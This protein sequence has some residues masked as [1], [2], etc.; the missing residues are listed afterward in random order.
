MGD[1]EQNITYYSQLFYYT[2]LYGNKDQITNLISVVQ[3]FSN[4]F[5]DSE[6]YN[7]EEDIII[8]QKI[9]DEPIK[10]YLENSKRIQ[11][12]NKKRF[13]KINP[14]IARI[15]AIYFK[16][17]VGGVPLNKKYYLDIKKPTPNNYLTLGDIVDIRAFLIERISSI[18]TKIVLANNVKFNFNFESFSK[19]GDATKFLGG[20]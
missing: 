1:N 11:S 10:F 9:G 14:T 16:D 7:Q 5:K 4:L 12:K 19:M 13:I 20:V 6:S 15:E 8:L 17:I 2:K 3:D 18:F